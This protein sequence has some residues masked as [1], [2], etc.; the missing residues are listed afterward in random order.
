MRKIKLCKRIIAFL[1]VL[2]FIMPGS[3]QNVYAQNDDITEENGVISNFKVNL[4]DYNRNTMNNITI[5]KVA[6]KL[7]NDINSGEVY[8]G[9]FLDKNKLHECYPALLFVSAGTVGKQSADYEYIDSETGLL[10]KGTVCEAD[11]N[12]TAYHDYNINNCGR[13]NGCSYQGIVQNRLSD[14]DVTKGFP[15]FN[16]ETADLFNP[17][18]SEN[19]KTSYLN[20]DMPFMLKDGYY[21]L[22]SE[23]YLY[24]ISE[25]KTKINIDSYNPNET[26]KNFLPLGKGNYHFGMSFLADFVMPEDGKYN[27][28]NCVFEFS[29]DDDLWV[30]IDGKLVLDLGGIHSVS[31]GKI[32]FTNQKVIYES[33]TNN[34]GTLCK[35]SREESFELEAKEQHTLKVFYLERGAAKSN[36]KIMFNLPTINDDMK[37]DFTFDKLDSATKDPV[38]GAEFTLY[39][40]AQFSNIV[41]KAESTVDG[42]VTFK[43]LA[44]GV[45][46]LKETGAPAGYKSNEDTYKL[47]VAGD[48]INGLI[49]KLEKVNDSNK[50]EIVSDKDDEG[51]F[52]IYNE[53]IENQINVDKTAKLKDWQDRTY[54]ITLKVNAYKPMSEDAVISTDANAQECQ[55]LYGDVIDIID[56][57]FELTENSKTF[58]QNDGAAIVYNSDGTTTI[59]WINQ[60]LL[61]WERKFEIKARDLYVGG[62]SVSTNDSDSRVII[63]DRESTVEQ[64]FPQPKVNVRIELTAGVARDEIFLGQSLENYFTDE[65]LKQMFDYSRDVRY[66]ADINT[67][68]LLYSWDVEGSDRPVYGTLDE[69]KQYVKTLY[70]RVSSETEPYKQLYISLTPSIEDKEQA[71]KDA[72]K[73]M[74]QNDDDPEYTACMSDENDTAINNVT[75]TG[76]YYVTI[77]DGKIT[78]NKTYDHGFLT[79]LIYSNDEIE[80]IDARQTAAFTIYKYAETATVDEISN[81]TAEI[82]DTYNIT[83]TGDGNQTITGLEAGMYR[84]VENTNWTW[85][86]NAT[87]QEANDSTTD[88]IFYIGKQSPNASVVN[89]ETVSF[90]NKLD[91]ELSKIYSDTTNI[92]NS[93]IGN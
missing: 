59:T 79:D 90:E 53:P 2:T 62:N 17:N 63:R 41:Q 37:G 10:E 36:C 75:A 70:P 48:N 66:F 13:Y 50:Y 31:K 38:S 87:V 9:D 84:V 3:S 27:N 56:S 30:Y 44:T 20:V 34:N 35:N 60:S 91:R 81:G 18:S 32:D 69:F 33:P 83:I 28:K 5:N 64:E 61:G 88:G 67:D 47:I 74:K 72:A 8:G 23:D 85:K 78:V 49:F 82:L 25:D 29:G 54:E 52:I 16:V 22:N 55:S 45:Y 26:K 24:S 65:Q 46:Y 57:R 6:N 93:F 7:Q 40:D 42:K 68:R 11:Y 43:D 51:D 86:Y 92:L 4:F 12:K 39:S 15:V 71:A 77:I 14:E 80:A 89:S 76:K 1:L 58:L 73:A 21:V 19:N